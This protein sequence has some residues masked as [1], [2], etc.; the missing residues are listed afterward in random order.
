MRNGLRWILL[1]VALGLITGCT[2]SQRTGWSGQEEMESVA[3]WNVLANDVA[4]RINNELIR[5]K[6]L[7]A[8]VHVRHSCGTP[9][10]CGPGE[11]YPF[12]EGF[13][14]LLTTQLVQFGVHTVATPEKANLLVDYK[15]QMVYHPGDW[16]AW[17]WPKPGVLTVL[18]AGIAVFHDVPWEIIPAAGAVDMFRA[19]YRDNGFYEVII[20][21][22]IVNDS[23]YVMRFSD[24]Y[25]VNNADLW[26]YR[27]TSPA[28]QIRLTGPSGTPSSATVQKASL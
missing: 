16:E 22:S 9:D 6:Q 5:Q 3:Q 2:R 14:D 1:V 24:I 25:Y 8:V 23:R 18:A 7:T 20:T 15:V 21:T 27:K 4:N 19:N 10:S 17:K 11:T 28:M 12:D 13:N 26:Q